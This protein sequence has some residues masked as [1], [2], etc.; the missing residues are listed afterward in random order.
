MIHKSPGYK[1]GL[2]YVIIS[3]QI[4]SIGQIVIFDLIFTH[5]NQN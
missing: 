1:P 2:F 5:W 4:S 3:L